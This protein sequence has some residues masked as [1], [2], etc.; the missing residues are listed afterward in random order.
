MQNSV[1]GFRPLSSLLSPH[2]YI[3]TI[4][5]FSCLLGFI[6]VT[7]HFELDVVQQHETLWNKLFLHVFSRVS[8]DK[9]NIWRI[10]Q[11]RL[12]GSFLL[13]LPAVLCKTPGRIMLWKKKHVP[14]LR[15]KKLQRNRSANSGS[16]EPFPTVIGREARY[17]PDRSPI[18]HR[19]NRETR[20]TIR[21]Y[22][23]IKITN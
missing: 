12:C 17:A 10:L 8:A 1:E 19:A 22:V 6:Q 16:L 20:T 4:S 15:K 11:E 21:N 7:N 18:Y 9:G 5:Y 2:T 23:R 13:N 14:D 3:K